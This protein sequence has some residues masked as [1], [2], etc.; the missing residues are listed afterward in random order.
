MRNLRIIPKLDIKNHNLVKGINL[1]GLRVLGDPKN[2]IKNYYLTGADEI[3]YHDVVASL[4]DRKQILDL[5]KRTA[6][7]TFLPITVGGGIKNID[8]ISDFL[9]SGADRIFANSSFIRNKKFI[10][11]CVSYFGS[12]TIVCAIEVLKKDNNYFCYAD[13]G[14]E[15]T[16]VKLEDWIVEIQDS[17]VGEIIITSI[18]SDGKG[19]GFDLNLAETIQKIIKIPYIVNGGFGELHHF[20]ELLNVCNPSGIALGSMLHYGFLNS[21]I[22]S[23][24]GNQTFLKTNQKFMN[25]G[26]YTL[27]DIKTHLSKRDI[28]R[29]I[30]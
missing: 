6:E 22:D 10:V 20:D 27:K 4:Y 17:G 25:F 21:P 11:E 30:T 3:I 24:E 7:N 14:R 16:K 29:P 12:S 26:N 5:V 19:R 23:S 1:E 9:N 13:F 18:H 28:I 15:E 2:F 8:E